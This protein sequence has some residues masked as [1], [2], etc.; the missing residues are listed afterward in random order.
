MRRCIGSHFVCCPCPQSATPAPDFRRTAPNDTAMAI[1]GWFE[2]M[3]ER[4]TPPSQ[5]N[6]ESGR[7]PF[8]GQSFIHGQSRQGAFHEKVAAFI[9]TEAFE[10]DP[11]HGYSTLSRSTK[12]SI[13]PKRRKESS[14][15]A[16]CAVLPGCHFFMPSR[17]SKGRTSG[18]S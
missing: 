17:R 8:H 5:M 9:E 15:K 14:N 1:C 2:T 7:R 18:S 12:A 4:P 10:V 6:T 13:V 3:P 11:L 16:Y